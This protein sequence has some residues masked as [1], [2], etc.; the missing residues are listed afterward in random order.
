MSIIASASTTMAS[1][2]AVAHFMGYEEHIVYVGMAGIGIVVLIAMLRFAY[3]CG[4]ISKPLG[5]LFRKLD[6]LDD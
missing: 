1:L 6:K 3:V 5:R 2:V 4:K